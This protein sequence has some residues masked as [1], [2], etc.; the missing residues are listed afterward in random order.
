MRTFHQYGALF[1]LD[2][3]VFRNHI[4]S[5]KCSLYG[6]FIKS[7]YCEKLNFGIPATNPPTKVHTTTIKACSFY[8]L[9]CRQ[10]VRKSNHRNVL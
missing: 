8:F 5:K 7:L 3:R 4:S 9:Y 1:F 10:H 6:L 2:S